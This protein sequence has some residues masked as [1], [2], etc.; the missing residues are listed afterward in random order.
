MLERI[1]HPA[2]DTAE[3][4]IALEN[5]LATVLQPATPSLH[6]CIYMA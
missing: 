2:P 3:H 1:Q 5:P 4:L 6:L